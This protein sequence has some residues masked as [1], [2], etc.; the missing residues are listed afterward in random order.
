MIQNLFRVIG[1]F[2]SKRHPRLIMLGLLL[3]FITAS[4]FRTIIPN[5]P[6]SDPDTWGYLNPALSKIAG[7]G[8]QQTHGRGIAYPLFLLA[9]FE[10]GGDFFTITSVQRVIGVLSGFLWWG[11]WRQWRLWMPDTIRDAFWLQSIGLLFLALYLWNA[12]AIYYEVCIRPESIFPFLALAQTWF[13]MA[14]ASARW[15]RYSFSI[16]VLTGSASILMAPVCISAK[17]S[18]GFSALVPIAVVFIG[19]IGKGGLSKF[20]LRSTPLIIGF[21]LALLWLKALPAL[22][23]WIPDERSQSFL[24]ATLFT[25][26]AP[27]IEKVLQARVDSGKATNEEGNFLLKWRTRIEESKHLEKTSYRILKHDPDYLFYHSD[28]IA[29]LPDSPLPEQRNKYMF[30]AYLEAVI[31]YPFEISLKVAEQLKTAFSNLTN[32]L[33]RRD[34]GWKKKLPGSLRSM[35]FYSLPNIGS[36]LV[37]SYEKVHQE[38]DRNLREAG[39]K[40]HF[41]PKTA[42][43]LMLGIGPVFIGF[44]MIAWPLIAIY[45]L[46]L[47]KQKNNPILDPALKAFGILWA[48]CLGTTLTVAIVHSFDIDR[49]LHLFSAQ[50]SILLAASLSMTFFYFSVFITRVVKSR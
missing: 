41:G 3:V 24:P 10:A 17:P 30:S 42:G 8:F 37:S 26:H 15:G 47:E 9:I 34:L 5:I 18:W 22:T 14:Y 50:H 6:I 29:S 40:I 31:H 35:D 45:S 1:T 46:Y 7:L 48:T 25:V 33:Y 28:A 13:C 21:F 36:E 49:Y 19:T 23:G 16:M 12:N 4:C 38:S 2:F 32:T 39:E 44:W 43:F 27:T 20:S 11:V